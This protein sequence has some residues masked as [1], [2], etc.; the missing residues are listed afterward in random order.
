MTQ[1][2]AGGGEQCVRVL[3]RGEVGR[4]GVVLLERVV[5]GVGVGGVTVRIELIWQFSIFS[6]H[7]HMMVF[8]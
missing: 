5:G 4:R 1:A 7:L 2:G 6:C 8:R 3:G